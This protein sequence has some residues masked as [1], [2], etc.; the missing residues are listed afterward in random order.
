MKLKIKKVVKSETVST[1]IT[2]EQLEKIEKLSKDN[3]LTKSSIIAHLIEV[4]YKTETKNKT[5]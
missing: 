2:P 3:N 5:F 4:G 1:K